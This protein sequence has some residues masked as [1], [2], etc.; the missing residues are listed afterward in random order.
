MPPSTSSQSAGAPATAS[1][2]LTGVLYVA[3][4]AASF[5]ALPIFIKI[6]YASGAE[7][8]AV[9]ALRFAFA[10]L[11]MSTIML[12]KGLP[13]PRGKNLL[14]LICMGGLGYVGQSFCFFS[15][16]NYA[17]AGLVSLLLYLYP[18]LVTVL[19]AIF[20]RQ[21]LS[22]FKFAAVM[23]ALAGT[24]LIIGGDAGGS[25]Q[26]VVLGI[27]AALIYS[28]YIL[29]GSRMM[30]AEGALPAATVVMLSAAG[31]FA[32]MAA[33]QQPVLPGSAS[34]WLAVVAI[35]VVSTVIAMVSF[36]AGLARLRASD[37][38]TISTLEPLVT[39][40]LAAFFL[41]EPI[42]PMKLVGGSIILIALVVLAR[43]R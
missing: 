32:V 9:L 37:A 15:A 20:L 19:G 27:S 33:I 39:V 14:I 38:A 11:L 28:I 25:L 30:R 2:P 26:G 4:S 22:R 43:T 23:A 35:A 21:R 1:T 13:W 16:L 36:F 5:G 18:A 42:T 8:V 40:I 31:V 3:L 17:S 34:G 7:P 41:G 10:A 6:A 12:A 24:A 29:V